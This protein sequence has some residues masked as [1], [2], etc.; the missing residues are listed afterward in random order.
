MKWLGPYT[1]QTIEDAGAEGMG[2]LVSPIAFVSEHIETLSELDHDY[3][4]LAEQVGCP[5]YL[6]APALGIEP[7]FVEG[8]GELVQNALVGPCAT[9]PGGPWRCDGRW[10]GCPRSKDAA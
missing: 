1:I 9:L 5:T 8:L 4:N 3:A 6:R 2:V 7:S 10:R